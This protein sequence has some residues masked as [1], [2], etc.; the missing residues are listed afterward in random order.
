MLAPWKKSFDQPRQY[1]KKQRHFFAN[2][3]SS[4]LTNVHLLKCM[5][6]LVVMYGCEILTIKKSECLKNW[7][8]WLC[9]WR[10]L[11][12]IPWTA[13]RFNQSILKEIVLNI[14]CNN[15]CWSWNSNT[16]A[17]RCKELTPLKRPW[18]WER[19]KMGGE[20][21]GRGWDSWVKSLIQWTWVWA[22][23]GFDMDREAWCAAA[24]VA[25]SDWVTELNW[26]LD[27]YINAYI[28]EKEIL[29]LVRHWLQTWC[30]SKLL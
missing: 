13:R 19:L 26:I 11:L 23:P 3:C 14:N 20:H 17:T 16:L 7:C 27:L 6:F 24:G 4:L 2:K 21:D 30:I 8:F 12:R 28:S 22:I 9:C 18:C 1:F 25:K 15:W 5:V 10:R 29:C